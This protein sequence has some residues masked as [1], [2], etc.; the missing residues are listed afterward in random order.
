M[1]WDVIGVAKRTF[2]HSG[3]GVDQLGDGGDGGVVV[4]VQVRALPAETVTMG[5]RWHALV[6]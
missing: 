4:R 3:R 2:E 6:T 1:C 5:C